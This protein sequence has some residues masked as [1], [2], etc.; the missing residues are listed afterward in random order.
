MKDTHSAM[1][2]HPLPFDRMVS[3]KE[4][5][6]MP[7]HEEK[8]RRT[9][10]S[11]IFNLGRGLY[12]AVIYP[13][14]VHAQD[15]NGEWQEIDNSLET[16]Q[17]AQGVFL[18]NR[19]NPDLRL[20][21]RPSSQDEMI[22]LE[23]GDGCYVAWTV[24]GAQDAIPHPVPCSCPEHAADDLRR[25]VL[26]LLD[27]EAIYEN[28]LP[29]ITLKCRVK[30]DS[31]KDEW[32]IATPDAAVPI[33]LL[34]KIP[35]LIPQMQGNGEIHLIASNGEIPY[36]LPKPFMQDANAS[37]IPGFVAV[38]M[39][40]VANQR[41]LW[42]ITYTPDASWLNTAQFPIVLDPA[43]ISK[44]HSTVMED[45]Y[46]SSKYPSTVQ[47]YGSGVIRITQGSSTWGTSKAFIRFLDSGLPDIDSS[48]YITKA[49]LTVKTAAKSSYGLTNNPTAAASLYLKE[50]LGPWSD[51]SI[52]YNNAPALN[53][54]A[55]DYVYVESAD[56]QY[57]FDISNLVRKW[58]TGVNYGVGLEVTTNTWINLYSANHAFYKPYVTINYVSLAGLESYLAYEQQS[59]GRAGTGYVSLYNG[60]LIFEHADTSSSGN[61]M[62]VSTAHYYN[63]CYYNLDMFGSGMGW[64]LNL[65]QCL[66]MELLGMDDANKT[67]YYVYMDADGTRHHFKLTSGKWKDLSGMGMELSISG[68]TATIT[69]KADNKMVFDL[70]TVEFTGSNFDALKMLKSVSDAC[71]NTMSLNFNESRMLGY[72]QDGAQRYTQAINGALLSSLWGPEGIDRSLGFDYDDLSRLT[73][74]THQDGSVT[75]YAYNTLGLLER[76][77]NIDGLT[78]TYSYTSNRASGPFRVSRVEIS[79]GGVYFGGRK[80]VYGDCLTKV[81]DL[82]PNDNGTALME[83]KALVYHF[84]DYGNVV[85]VNDELGYACFA[86][87][88]D[89]LPANHP[90]VTSKM[91]RAVVNLLRNHN[92]ESASDWTLSGNWSYATDSKYM[93][94]RSLKIT[95]QGVTYMHTAKQSVVITP[96]K[97]YT[98]S[99][100]VRKSGA[101]DVWVAYVYTDASGVSQ[102]VHAPSMMNQLTDDFSRLSYTFTV[103]ENAGNTIQVVLCAGAANGIYPSAWFD[104]AQ[105]EEGPVANSYNMLINGDFTLNSGAHPTGWN[106]NSSNTSMDIVYPSCTGTKPEGLSS[107][108]MRMYG[109]GRTKYAG[110]YQDI[111][112]SGNQGD[113]FSAGGWSLNFSKPRKG[114][115]FRYNIRVAFLKSGTSTRVNSDSIEWS[116]E[117]TDWQFAAG[118]VIA[119]CNYTSIR[120]NVD[121]ERNINYAEFNGLFLYK[122]EFGQ[123]YVYDSNGNIL[124]AKN[125]ASLQDGATYDA[126]NNMLTY[127]QPGRPANVKTTLEWGNS[128]E[129]KK[130]HLLRK[131]TSPLGIVNEYTYNAQG[132][133][134]S[135]KT[136]DG[137]NFM[138]TTTSYDESGNHITSQVDTRGKVISRNTDSTL[139]TLTSITDP[140]GQTINYD[141]DQNRRMTKTFFSTAGKEYANH[142]TYTQ[143][144]LSQI[145][146]N[147]SANAEDDVVYNFEYDAVGRPTAVKVNNQVLSSTTYNAD[148]TIQRVDYGNGD[149]IQNNYDAYKRLTGVRYRWDAEDRYSYEYGANGKVARVKNTELNTCITSEYDTAGRPMRISHMRTDY[150]EHLYTGEVAY[151]QYNNLS[152]FKEQVGADRSGY[153]TTY[154]YDNDNRPTKLAFGNSRQV[155]Y[156]YDGLGRVSKRTVNT[157]GSDMETTY[158]YLPG[159]HGTNSTTPFV[160]TITQN[161]VTLTYTY[162]DGGNISSVSDGSKTIS[163]EYDLLGQLIRTND[164]YDLTGGNAGTTWLYTYDQG[165]N[166]QIKAAY[167]YTLG[168]V[169]AVVK[170]DTFSYGDAN[171][172]DKLTTFN[173]G[174]ISYD[175]I[176]NPLNN[177][178]W[179]YSWVDGRR[180]R[181]VYKGEYNQPGHDEILFDYNEDG[182]RTKKTRLH[183]DESSGSLVYAST[184]YILHGKN[185]VHMTSNGHTMHF[186]YDAQNRPAVVV[187]DGTP[188]AFRYNLQGDVIALAD[189]NGNKIVEYKYDVWGR[190]LSTT[191]ALAQSLGMLNP[192]KYRGYVYDEETGLYY[193][194]NRYY[195]PLWGR[196]I[197]SDNYLVQTQSLLCHNA[198]CYCTNSPVSLFDPDGTMALSAVA[199]EAFIAGMGIA[200]APVLTAIIGLTV[201]I[202]LGIGIGAAM[203]T[204][205]KTVEATAEAVRIHHDT[206]AHIIESIEKIKIEED[207][208]YDNSI[209]VLK[210]K[211][212]NVHYVGITNEV[213]R[214]AAEHKRDKIHPGRSNYDMVVIATGLSKEEARTGEQVLISAYTL[215]ALDNARREIA[216]RNIHKFLNEIHRI[217]ELWEIDNF[218]LD[219]L[220]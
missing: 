24:E 12:Q 52:T 50:V 176:G 192:F 107:N 117:W 54:K 73:S 53:D 57:T 21:L 23:D 220:K 87:Y 68:T 147:T 157:G 133:S 201:V 121:Y 38:S 61:L 127:Y 80:Y 159:G 20:T 214:R 103:P 120:F 62:P 109:T 123:T 82:V 130:K 2:P 173:G 60:N 16:H 92:F 190:I 110:I 93:G 182:L 76:I 208:T 86:K 105:L 51:T 8:A 219:M 100:Y 129:E 195:N 140:H 69:D 151:D 178:T 99:F 218:P 29:G 102:W 41:D 43:V 40:P 150:N 164:P 70:P 65:Q 216:V 90:E 33:T 27:S 217:A 149:F 10:S 98:F 46:I 207:Q 179:N 138:Q 154:T 137:T 64:K 183:Y 28:I 101:I 139:D 189:N 135:A 197:N 32:I 26:D 94:A 111:P 165:G 7:G 163:Y 47:E 71:G 79:N 142:Y 15:A 44:K 126:F 116:E 115:N 11:K 36:V 22:R 30:S 180:L 112:V 5:N 84:N 203:A 166:I 31:F 160:Q 58:Y 211:E 34:L 1:R 89:A 212:N 204:L 167:A 63:S 158:N 161:G 114:E 144:K 17:D 97:T 56:T 185:I 35:N 206:A 134:V 194:Q 205:I 210:D 152:S 198:F 9:R 155:T 177:G 162:D 132:S 75:T 141:Y 187:Y 108:T 113:V 77:T 91:Q 72:A 131:S 128:D 3:A 199:A 156:V 186:F 85:S 143:D 148:G 171:W 78:L 215:E 18:C 45:N 174:S 13:E 193:L 119:P 39:Q 200:V 188:Y 153:V 172:K 145:R 202:G 184:E 124:S 88:S 122:E 25:N 6:Q 118:P 14:P 67:T 81:I 66:H 168:A 146:H 55:L 42:R 136:F 104:C 213:G 49:E 19:Q 106:K 125:A 209:Y 191:G 48:Y 37:E 96:G 169:G 59:A 95:T 4:M 181:A 175:E 74:I 196:F 83:G 170:T